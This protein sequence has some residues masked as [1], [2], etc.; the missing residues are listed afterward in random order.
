MATVTVD[1]MVELRGLAA[2]VTGDD[3][4]ILMGYYDINDGGQGGFAWDTTSTEDDNG[5]TIILPDG[6]VG[7]GRWKRVCE[8][9]VLNVKWFGAVGDY[10]TDDTDAFRRC[11]DALPEDSST[12]LIGAA[13]RGGTMLIPFGNFSLD[14]EFIINRHVHIVGVNDCNT[15]WS[16]SVINFP[17]DSNGFIF[18]YEGGINLNFG[19]GASIRQVAIWSRGCSDI[20]NLYSYL[21]CGTL[22]NGDFD[23]ILKSSRNCVYIGQSPNDCQV[24]LVGDSGDGVSVVDTRVGRIDGVPALCTIHYESGVSTVGD[25]EDA[26][27]KRWLRSTPY[28]VGDIVT[29]D[30]NDNTL[31]INR[32]GCITS[33]TSATGTAFGPTGTAS[34]ITD[35][36][37]H[38]EYLG[39]GTTLI[40]V[41]TT[42]T[43]GTVLTAPGDN[44]ATADLDGAIVAHGVTFYAGGCKV[45]DCDI[46][47][48][49]GNGAHIQA[50]ATS[51]GYD[52]GNAQFWLLARV[53][54]YGNLG[55]GVY[56]F[57]H[58]V[59]VGTAS[60]V[61]C[62]H[63]GRHGF[64]EESGFANK[65]DN[66][67]AFAAGDSDALA[68][69]GYSTLDASAAC[70]VSCYAEGNAFA[71][72]L[73][74]NTTWFGPGTSDGTPL[75]GSQVLAGQS[76]AITLGNGVGTEIVPLRLLRDGNI[77]LNQVQMEKTASFSSVAL[78]AIGRDGRIGFLYP[79]G[80]GKPC[81]SFGV[82][83]GWQP[84]YDF[85]DDTDG[86][87]IRF[88]C[89]MGGGTFPV[90]QF[91][92]YRDG[93]TNFADG[94]LTY[95]TWS[96][97]PAFVD[98]FTMKGGKIGAG[99]V[100]NPVSTI[101]ADGD[102]ETNN[103][104]SGFI[105]KSPNG[106]RWRIA[107][108]N[109]GVL[110]TNAV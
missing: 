75:G 106:T 63:I 8:T 71:P 109:G 29:N 91:R 13:H 90:G 99:G 28:T 47:N 36:T 62:T 1:S 45:I 105:L 37:A 74:S 14:G 69:Y 97:D 108:S 2:G 6:Y 24:T 88:G 77:G 15:G 51:P 86:P 107:V 110:S 103:V 101:E 5:G 79:S 17:I 16:A 11:M 68:S 53:E 60:Q 94:R 82:G 89:T 3:R 34:D 9:G 54:I 23:T 21:D 76:G 70:F 67:H 73:G 52:L 50:D 26:I 38:W 85:N 41:A 7:T 46:R 31:T 49:P 72:K 48:F 80:G 20:T 78:W 4:A 19:H 56:V 83:G 87:G 81:P 57:G 59:N 12:P 43:T 93:G 61:N 27:G 66:C 44:F 55:D 98:T 40:Q 104:G 92:A 100:I 39:L 64:R 84:L 30:A 58:D 18:S 33:G 42:G 102:I 96:N 22:A 32:Y 65:Y 25:I 35:G 95:Q 10:D